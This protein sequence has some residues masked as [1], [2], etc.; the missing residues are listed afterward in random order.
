MTGGGNIF[1]VIVIVACMMLISLI[2]FL[3]VDYVVIV[4]VVFLLEQIHDYI[5][6]VELGMGMDDIFDLAISMQ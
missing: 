1:I 2:V 5:D 4:W 3:R 6:I